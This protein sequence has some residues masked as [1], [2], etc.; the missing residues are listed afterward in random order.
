MSQGPNSRVLGVRVRV[1][2]SHNH[3]VADPKVPAVGLR[4]PSLRSP[5]SQ[6]PRV[7]GPDFRLCQD[8]MGISS[9]FS[10]S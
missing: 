8:L 1:S 5:G 4:V 9:Q 6:E 7:T 3:K 10:F 2:E